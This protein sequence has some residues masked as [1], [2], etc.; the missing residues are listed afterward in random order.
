MT[1]TLLPSGVFCFPKELQFLF[2]I[3]DI[4]L[5]NNGTNHTNHC[6]TTDI[7]N[8]SSY[9]HGWWD[10]IAGYYGHIDS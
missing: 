6:S 1:K 10:H 2:K 9:R 4:H 3:N 8:L 7:I 5:K